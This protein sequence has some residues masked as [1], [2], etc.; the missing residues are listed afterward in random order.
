[1]NIFNG[2]LKDGLFS[3]KYLRQRVDLNT[4]KKS[5]GFVT[6]RHLYVEVLYTEILYLC[7]N[8]HLLKDAALLHFH[9]KESSENMIF[10]WKGNIRKLTKIWSFLPFSQILVRR[11]FKFSCSYFH[12][13]CTLSSNVLRVG[14]GDRNK[15]CKTRSLFFTLTQLPYDEIKK[16]K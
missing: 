12:A 16:T 6:I 7:K 4:S 14:Y 2:K 5:L 15:E 1:M 13:V 11:K 9:L 8:T 10:L 3:L